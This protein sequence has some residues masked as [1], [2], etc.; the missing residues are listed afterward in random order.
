MRSRKK[1]KLKQFKCL[2]KTWKG[3]H[4]PLKAPPAFLLLFLSPLAFASFS[5]PTLLCF[6][7]LSSSPPRVLL[8]PPV[9][10]RR[11]L[12]MDPGY[13]GGCKM[14]VVDEYGNLLQTAKMV[15][16]AYPNQQPSAHQKAQNFKL[17][18]QLVQQ[19]K[20]NLIAIGTVK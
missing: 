10:G 15:I 19:H 7:S 20:V 11:V 6:I 1:P 16:V 5:L 18:V 2:L 3:N 17:F 12:S 4:M 8:T 9:R 14:A 13:T